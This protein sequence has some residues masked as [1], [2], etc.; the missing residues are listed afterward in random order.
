MA[1]RSKDGQIGE[2]VGDSYVRLSGTSMAT[3]HVAGAA[4]I[5][6]QQHPDWTAGPLKATLMGSAKPNPALGVFAQGAGRVDVARAISQTIV[7]D[8][9]S[10]SFGTQLWPHNDDEVLTRTVTYHNSGAAAATVAIIVDATGPNG[11]AVPAGT[12]A[13]QP[14]P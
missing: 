9:A 2:P 8:Q 14:A 10:I 3:P 6:A 1:A 7:A 5:L 11:A 4:A 12:F 13:V